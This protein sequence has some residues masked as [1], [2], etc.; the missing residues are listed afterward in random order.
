LADLI[1]KDSN[2]T[3]IIE[4][5]HL[6]ITGIVQGVGYRWSMVREAKRLGLTGWVRNRIDGSVEAVACGDNA[7]VASLI[8]WARSGPTG[9]RVEQVYVERI[10]PTDEQFSGFVQRETQ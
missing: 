3:D 1:V 4:I 5:R 9:A 2:A 6:Q 8:A 10:A 7:A